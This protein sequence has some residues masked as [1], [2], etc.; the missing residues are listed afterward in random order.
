MAQ[1]LTAVKRELVVN[2]YMEDVSWTRKVVGWRVTIYDKSPKPMDGTIPLPNV[3]YEH[4]TFLHHIINNYKD[5]ASITAFTQGEP[6]DYNP[7]FVRDLAR[8]PGDADYLPLSGKPWACDRTGYPDHPPGTEIPIPAVWDMLF[9][10]PCPFILRGMANGIMAVSRDR[11]RRRGPRF[12]KA[13]IELISKD[14][15]TPI[16][17][18]IERLW[19]YVFSDTP[20]K[21]EWD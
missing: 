11:I 10:T 3:G 20:G 21:K 16:I 17:Y 19:P 12:Y 7:R 5:L 1:K 18:V 15:Y 8:V 9:A 2:R 13:M 14:R 4:H 6:Q